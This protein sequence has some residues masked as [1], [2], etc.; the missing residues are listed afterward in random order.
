M[1]PAATRDA[2]LHR[3]LRIHDLHGCQAFR[4]V[5]AASVACHLM[6]ALAPRRVSLPTGYRIEVAST[7]EEN[8]MGQGSIAAGALLM[9][10]I[11]FTLLAINW[12]AGRDR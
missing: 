11:M 2:S 1:C 10:V 8:N 6:P 7:T 12:A 4:G 9:L 5:N 3:K